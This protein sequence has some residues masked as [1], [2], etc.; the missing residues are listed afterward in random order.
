MNQQRRN[1]KRGVGKAVVFLL[2]IAAAGVLFRFTPVREMITPA[3]LERLVSSFGLWAPLVF[4]LVYALGICVFLPALL[5]T[6]IGAVLFGPL[7]GF[8][9][10]EIGALLGASAAFFIGRYLGRDFAA[11]LI[12]D[13][14]KK[15]DDKIAANGFATV[16]Y[17]RLVFFPFTPLNF[18]MGLTRVGFKD[19]FFG[20]LFGI[21]A[22]G[23]VLTFFFA[24][25]AEVW[26]SGNWAQLLSGKTLLS[27]L[28]FVASFFIPKV[29]NKLRPQFAV[30]K[31]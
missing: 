27:L 13:R 9:Y 11:S 30:S 6:G 20:T 22:G 24:T 29:V 26:K 8:I 21:I 28:L 5:F 25:L 1:T 7:Y 19:Y 23:F 10:N 31:G 2:F 17:L 14:L 12:G 18:G 3:N 4:I 15:Y 16:L